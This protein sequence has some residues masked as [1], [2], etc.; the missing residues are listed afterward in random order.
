MMLIDLLEL[1][2]TRALLSGWE[3]IIILLAV[4]VILIWGPAKIPELAKGL[5]RAKGEFEKAASDYSR[6]TP[7]PEKK[8]DVSSDNMLI[9]IAKGLGI[10]TEGKT[11]EKIFQEIIENIKT[12]KATS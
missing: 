6:A 9:A 8:T 7:E 1:E 5:G 2:R 10:N 12:S 4:V 11:K 3:W